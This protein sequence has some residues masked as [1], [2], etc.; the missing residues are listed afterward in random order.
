MATKKVS[1]A[2]IL[3]AIETFLITIKTHAPFL[4]FSSFDFPLRGTFS[5]KFG[6]Y[7]H[8]TTIFRGGG[9]K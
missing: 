1:I 8:Q 6:I 4:C 2:K 3:V 7:M 5:V 9:I